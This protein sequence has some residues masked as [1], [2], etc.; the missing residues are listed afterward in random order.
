MELNLQRVV[1]N[2]LTKNEMN[3]IQQPSNSLDM[4][5]C[6]FFQ[7]DRV[8]KPL[9]CKGSPQCIRC[10]QDRHAKQEECSRVNLPPICCNCLAATENIP[11][12]DARKIINNSNNLSNLN[13]NHNSGDFTSLRTRSHM[14]NLA[15]F[16]SHNPYDLLQNNAS[17]NSFRSYAHNVPGNDL[18]FWLSSNEAISKLCPSLSRQEIIMINHL[19]SNHY[20][21]NESLYQCI[22]HVIFENNLY[23]Y[24]ALRLRSYFHNK[25]P[26][27]PEDIFP[28]LSHPPPQVM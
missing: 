16:E 8:K 17:S 14:G 26:N 25:Y 9:L 21:L 20:N 28:L 18:K 19:R 10:G 27:S 2:F 15:N 6:D 1:L 12:A 5:P 11:I 23:N 22:N 4:A 13:L 7:F 24:K 3:T